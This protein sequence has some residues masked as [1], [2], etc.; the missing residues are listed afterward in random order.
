MLTAV[1]AACG[2]SP[3]APSAADAAP[4][5]ARPVGL[6]TSLAADAAVAA[7]RRFGRATSS[8]ADAAVEAAGRFRVATCSACFCAS[9]CQ[10]RKCHPGNFFVEAE[11]TQAVSHFT[12]HCSDGQMVLCDLQDLAD[13]P[14][15]PPDRPRLLPGMVVERLVWLWGAFGR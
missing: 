12:Y 9:P 5:A 10:R 6:A 11:L 2:F 14:A 13:R 4:A 7:A 3:A 1:A 15:C 8:A